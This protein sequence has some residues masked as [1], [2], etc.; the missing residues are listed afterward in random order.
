MVPRRNERQVSRP[1]RL[2]PHP[3]PIE[4]LQRRLHMLDGGGCFANGVKG[5]NVACGSQALVAC[6]FCVG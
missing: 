5:T 4:H 3:L 6:E 1:L 2:L